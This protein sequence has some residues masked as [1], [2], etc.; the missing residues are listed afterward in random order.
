MPSPYGLEIVENCQHCKLR[1]GRSFCA[2]PGPILDALQR[3]G[4]ATACPKGSVL[5]AQSQLAREVAILCAGHVKIS[6]TS[7]DGRKICLEIAGPG[8]VLGL[9]AAISGKPHQ[10]LIEAIEPCQLRIIKTDR[11]LALLRKDPEACFAAV[12]CLSDEVR[13]M[14]GCIRLFGLSHSTA[15]KLARVLVEWDIR[16]D[17]EEGKLLLR[18]SLTHQELAE[19]LGVA[20]E[21][22]TRVLATFEHKDLIRCRGATLVIE[23]ERTLRV[24][25]R[26]T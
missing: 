19:I 16:E 24:L 2:V 15:E 5:L 8:T 9:T 6:T 17:D 26:A 11:L 20:R 23:D 3:L 10:V 18:I 7:P 12:R 1:T 22:V 21:T 14:L 13:R 4:F 25:A